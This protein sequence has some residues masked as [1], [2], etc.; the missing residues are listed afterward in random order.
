M[1]GTRRTVAATALAVVA[2]LAS[3]CPVEPTGPTDPTGPVWTPHHAGG[4]AVGGATPWA[5]AIG[6]TED[7]YA[8][9]DVGFPLTAPPTVS[10][11]PRT[12]PDIELGVP[13][14]GRADQIGRAHV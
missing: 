6:T 3:G 1:R 2:V 7:W 11:F 10:V 5:I 14:L 9:L 4:P 13:V 12:G 8:Q